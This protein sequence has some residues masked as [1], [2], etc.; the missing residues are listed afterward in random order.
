MAGSTYLANYL[1]YL[2]DYQ[3]D[4]IES[5]MIGAC[6]DHL[7]D[8]VDK[9]MLELDRTTVVVDTG[10]VTRDLRCGHQDH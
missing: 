1:V 6:D 7:V 8:I 10:R 5:T 9:V 3:G 4:I 2:T